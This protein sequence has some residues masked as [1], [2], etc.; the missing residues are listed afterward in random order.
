MANALNA[1]R[2]KL[3]NDPS[4][5]N[6]LMASGRSAAAVGGRRFRVPAEIL[7]HRKRLPVHEYRDSFLEA[8]QRN[9]VLIV[10]GETGS[11]KTTQL[12]QYLYEAGYGQRGV[13]GITL[14]RC[15][16][17]LIDYLNDYN[18]GSEYKELVIGTL[19]NK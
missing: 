5:L 15:A 7:E 3:S 1:T 10:M 17:R 8:V 18:D 2:V 12:P 19:H 6:S 13:I 14:P 9:S 11:G 16:I 4:H